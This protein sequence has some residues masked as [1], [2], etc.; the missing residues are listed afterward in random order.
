MAVSAVN[1]TFDE[2]LIFMTAGHA[3]KTTLTRPD[4]VAPRCPWVGFA[5]LTATLRH[6]QNDEPRGQVHFS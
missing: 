6:L 4:N 5:A 3:S 2:V 1:P